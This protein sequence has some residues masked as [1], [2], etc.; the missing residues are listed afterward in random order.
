MD[1]TEPLSE[2]PMFTFYIVECD[3][4]DV[5]AYFRGKCLDR[6]INSHGNDETFDTMYSMVRGDDAK[7]DYQF[8]SAAQKHLVKH[9]MFLDLYGAWGDHR[10]SR[11]NSNPKFTLIEAQKLSFF[12]QEYAELAWFLQKPIYG[13]SSTIRW[14][15]SMLDVTD[16]NPILLSEPLKHTLFNEWRPGPLVDEN[17]QIIVH[18]DYSLSRGR[19]KFS[20]SQTGTPLVFED[21]E[22]LKNRRIVD[23]FNRTILLT[24]LEYFGIDPIALIRDRDLSD[25]VMFVST[26]EGEPLDG[27]IED[28]KKYRDIPFKYGGYGDAQ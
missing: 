21:M 28:L 20:I 22:A 8:C 19:M 25:A 7:I 4:N 27:Y 1:E 10:I 5:E 12:P 11:I 9:P 14:D 2:I 13:F 16:R 23:R 3:V 18:G 24:Y 15:I 6:Q 26:G 17:R